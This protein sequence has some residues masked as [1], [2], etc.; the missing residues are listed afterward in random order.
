MF[1]NNF[2]RKGILF[3]L[4]APSGGGKTSI[5]TKVREQYGDIKVSISYTSRPKRDNEVNGK[6]YHF[7]ERSEFTKLIDEGFFIETAEV[8][9][10]FYGIPKG[11]LSP[12][13]EKGIDYIFAITY[14]GYE[15]LKEEF[16]DN[17]VGIFIA[18]ESR[19][20]LEERLIKRNTESKESLN[21][22]LKD[23]NA[24]LELAKQYEYLVI[25]DQLEKAVNKV[26]CIIEAEKLKYIRLKRG[27]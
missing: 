21:N 11:D 16:P 6:D 7:I 27:I 25:N 8:F 1:I 2:E 17:V 19:K 14:H 3:V 9:G 22:R 23:L 18:P 4:S 26:S 5:I 20:I 13:L 24:E 12:D 10:N 15:K